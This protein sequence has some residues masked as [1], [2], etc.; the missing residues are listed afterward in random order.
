MTGFQVVSDHMIF[1]LKNG[2]IFEHL[3]SRVFGNL[4]N[5]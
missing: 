2:V 4:Y 5:N 3:N 1:V